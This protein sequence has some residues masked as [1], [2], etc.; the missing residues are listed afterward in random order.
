MARKNVSDQNATDR[1]RGK[2]RFVSGI[3]DKG[4][5]ELARHLCPGI[6][7]YQIHPQIPPGH[8]APGACN[9]TVDSDQF[10]GVTQ[11]VR[12]ALTELVTIAPVRRGLAASEQT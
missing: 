11:N 7:L 6:T 1:R 4:F 3:N 9:R 5:C 8:T 2:G 12:I 10:L